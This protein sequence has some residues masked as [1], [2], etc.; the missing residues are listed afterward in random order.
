MKKIPVT[1][2]TVYLLCL[3]LI[4]LLFMSSA[5]MAQDDTSVDEGEEI[6][7]TDTTDGGS[8]GDEMAEDEDMAIDNPGEESMETEMEE[9]AVPV[10]YDFVMPTGLEVNDRR[11]DEGGAFA[12]TW[13]VSESDSDDYEYWIFHSNA[14]RP[15]YW[16]LVDSFPTTSKYYW[17]KPQ[18]F[19]FFLNEHRTGKN[20][21]YSLQE[22]YYPK[23]GIYHYEIK[24]IV[25]DDFEGISESDPKTLEISASV[26]DPSITDYSN[27]MVFCDLRRAGGEKIQLTYITRDEIIAEQEAAAGEEFD[28]DDVVFMPWDNEFRGEFTLDTSHLLETKPKYI[29][30]TSSVRGENRVTL[31]ITPS[32]VEDFGMILKGSAS[33]GDVPDNRD[34]HSY[35]L[36]VVPTGYALPHGED[37]PPDEWMAGMI[38]GNIAHGNLWAMHKNN[39]FI[40]ALFICGAVMIYIFLARGQGQLFIRRIAG[41]DHVEEAIGRATEMGRPILYVTGLGYM[42]DIA[43]IASVNI[44]G[45][46]A[47]RV[48]AYESRLL[49]PNRDAIVMAVCQEV[50]KEA[51][52]D[53]G[54]PDAFNNDDVFFITDDQFAYTAAVDGIMMREKPATNFFMG[55]FYAESLLLAETG[56]ST[57]A[58]QIAGTDALAQLPFFIT[59]CDYTLIGEELYAASAYLSR[60]PMLLGSLKGQ[61]LSKMIFMVMILIGTIFLCVNAEWDFIKTLFLAF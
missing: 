11:N 41:L 3:S 24:T 50:V 15:D 6:A 30:F 37:F 43:T 10:E 17:E 58:I 61:D 38:D 14:L 12:I 29:P 49:V 40:F 59:A 48:A 52:I 55:L 26:Y 36:Y 23:P 7:A 39:I 31:G 4:L 8:S 27:V 53:S 42:S 45:R 51:Y 18:Y 33:T 21:H 13:N 34:Q 60:E 2:G 25:P 44:L 22:N 28:P 5:T 32:H 35:R 56:A 19:G 16:E 54:H 9:E 47:R 20:L 46:V 1:N 57:G